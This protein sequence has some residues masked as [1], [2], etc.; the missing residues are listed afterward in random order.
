MKVKKKAEYNDLKMELWLRMRD[1]GELVWVT[2]EGKE[3]PIKD[4][5]TEHL[6]NALRCLE[7]KDDMIA[8]S[9]QERD[10]EY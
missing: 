1:A 4:M 10:Y 3:I 8:A 5:S 7:W 9:I 6:I 2:K